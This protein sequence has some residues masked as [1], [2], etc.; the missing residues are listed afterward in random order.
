MGEVE[1]EAWEFGEWLGEVRF[2]ALGEMEL[3]VNAGGF[4]GWDAF[5]A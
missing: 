1:V 2:L 5:N 3:E 4:V